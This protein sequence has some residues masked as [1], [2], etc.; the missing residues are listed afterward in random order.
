[1]I[2]VSVIIPVYNVEPYLAQCLESVLA[3]SLKEI[4]IICINDGSMDRSPEILKEYAKKNL[5]IKIL[6]Q[7]N[8]G[9]SVARNRGVLEAHGEYLY[10]MDSDDLIVSH[11]L[12]ELWTICNRENLDVL[13]F[14]GTSFYESDALAKRHQAFKNS[15][16]RKGSYTA[17]VSGPEMLAQLKQNSDYFVSPCLQ[18]VRRELLIRNRIE[19]QEGIIHED[20][21]FS[22]QVVLAA[23]K[24]FCVNDVYFYRRVHQ[25]SVMTR[26]ENHRNLQGYFVCLIKQL[27]WAA[28]QNIQDT[29]INAAIES[30]LMLLF[31]HVQRIYISLS[32]SEREKF[33][34]LCNPYERYLFQSVILKSIW[35]R[36]DAERQHRER[37]IYRQDLD[38]IYHS[39]SFRIS[40]IVIYLPRKLY[41]G[42]KCLKEN[43]FHYT[44]KRA[45]QKVKEKLVR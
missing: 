45:L 31:L 40:R 28:R 19:F 42:C 17:P 8:K 14:S 15:Y 32:T 13:Y 5:Q 29:R 7:V 9:Q 33:L 34:N 11:A 30:V 4:E 24:T 20:N 12:E 41:R 1:M 21:C 39:K 16:Y 18:L 2:K 44:V 3:Q 10:F 6:D 38:A 23:E 27:E 22:F 35:Q 25:S 26:K 36:V 43:G 37:E